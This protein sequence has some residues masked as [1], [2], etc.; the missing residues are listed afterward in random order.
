M[1]SRQHFVPDLPGVGLVRSPLRLQKQLLETHL[2][3]FVLRRSE[4]KSLSARLRGVEAGNEKSCG[5]GR[6]VHLVGFDDGSS[7]FFDVETA[8]VLNH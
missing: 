3:V 6:C 4:T 1:D 2:S 5:H 7:V 8:S